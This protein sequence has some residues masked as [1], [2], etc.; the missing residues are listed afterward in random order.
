M[1]ILCKFAQC[2]I[3]REWQGWPPEPILLSDIVAQNV[4]NCYVENRWLVRMVVAQNGWLSCYAPTILAAKFQQPPMTIIVMMGSWLNSSGFVIG[5]VAWR[6]WYWKDTESR[7]T[8]PMLDAQCLDWVPP[9]LWAH[10]SIVAF[11][12][13]CAIVSARKKCIGYWFSFCHKMSSKTIQTAA[14]I[15]AMIRD[16]DGGVDD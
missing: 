5:L 10:C 4:N 7:S 16:N 15:T 9:D 14:T 2:L 11:A 6:C 8:L 13:M 1:C 3:C 12:Y